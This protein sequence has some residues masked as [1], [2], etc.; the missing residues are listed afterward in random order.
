MY[1]SSYLAL[2]ITGKC[3]LAC[4]HCYAE[5]GPTGTHGSMAVDDWKALITQ[6]ASI[7]FPAIQ[8]IGGEPTTHP[9]FAQLLRYAVDAGL[10]VEVFS[11]LV[12]VKDAWW[13]LFGHPRVSL[14]TSYYSDT[15]ADH[16]RVTGRRA[17]HPRTR[18]N[19]IEALR[20][21][22]PLRVEIVDVLDGQRVEQARTELKALGVTNIRVNRLRGVGRAAST[23]QAASELCGRCGHG[24][25]AVSPTG[26]VSPCLMSRWMR[27]GNVQQ[28]SLTEILNGPAMRSLVATIEQ[29]TTRAAICPPQTDGCSPFNTCTPDFPCSPDR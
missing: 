20:R 23:G 7:G 11:N 22:V 2:E 18:A 27:T 5:S 1:P 10:T 13:E 24:T 26:D 6:A 15:A 19:I 14:A 4:V 16:Q 9:R 29:E 21:G 12:H 3:Q 25:A 8:F 28:R 17:S